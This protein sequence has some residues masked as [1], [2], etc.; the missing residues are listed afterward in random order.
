MVDAPLTSLNAA[1]CDRLFQK[2]EI[3]NVLTLP[4]ARDA[5]R[6][7]TSWLTMGMSDSDKKHWREIAE[8]ATNEQDPE[9]LLQLAKQLELAL[10]EA[11]SQAL[12][13]KSPSVTRDKAAGEKA[14]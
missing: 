10:D 11:H 8:E 13:K 14:G 5:I 9:K 12:S 6:K 1:Y 7:H 2:P 4:G 3:Y